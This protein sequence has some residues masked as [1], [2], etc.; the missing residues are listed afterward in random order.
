MCLRF[1]VI[2]LLFC[3]KITAQ[4][5]CGISGKPSSLIVNGTE[6]AK[7]AW[8][9]IVAVFKTSGDQF[10]CGGTLISSNLVLTVSLIFT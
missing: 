2:S 7:G 5:V 9:W 8:P 3:S 10:I 4:N 1:F 6:S